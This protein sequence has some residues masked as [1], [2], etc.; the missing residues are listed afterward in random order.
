MKLSS[1]Y[2]MPKSVALN[3]AW[4]KKILE[5]GYSDK[6]FAE[7]FKEECAKDP[8]LFMNSM[9]WILESRDE[10]DWQDNRKFGAARELP[11]IT[12][13][14]QDEIVM[15]SLPCLGKRDIPMVK[16]REMGVSYIY[17]G[18]AVWDAVFHGH[19]HIGLV[20]KDL[21]SADSPKDPDALFSKVVFILERLPVWLL[22]KQGKGWERSLSEHTIEF[23]E[24][25]SSLTA[26][27]AVANLGRGG[28]KRWFLF[29]EF[30]FFPEGDDQ[31]ALDSTAQATNCRALIS[32]VNR[33]RGQT[34]AFYEMINNQEHNGEIIDIS[35]MD[36][37]EKT[38]GRYHS[39]RIAGT[40]AYRLVIDD[41]AFWNTQLNEDGTYRD[42][43][44]EGKNYAFISDGRVRSLYYDWC[45]R[46]PG[47]TP[48][49]IAAELD[50]NFAGAT[51]SVMDIRLLDD[52]IKVARKP[53]ELGEIYRDPQ[54]HTKWIFD[55]GI[56]GGTTKL[57]LD[58]SNKKPPA[59][60]DYSFGADISMGTGG[61][62]SSYSCLVGFDKRT[63]EQVFE[64][65]SNTMNPE[66]FASLA[67][68][69]CK[70]FNNAYLVPESNGPGNMFLKGLIAEKYVTNV[71]RSR[72]NDKRRAKKTETLGYH[73]PD[74]GRT[75]L[76]S[77]ELAMQRG[78]PKINS[79]VALR[80][81]K[82]YFF[83]SDGKPVHAGA[84][85]EE[86]Q[87]AVG[88]SHGDAAIAVCCAWMGV[89]DEPVKPIV[90]EKKGI[91]DNCFLARRQRYLEQQ[92][93]KTRV[94][95]WNPR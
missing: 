82:R 46:R 44:H 72:P 78:G 85:N 23:I 31:A 4:R 49:S 52:A 57:W 65:R 16:S 35:W 93:A 51:T 75:L 2:P 5:L 47:A 54:D 1:A 19:T 25:K 36:D 33:S 50:R 15:R 81:M 32:T 18:L 8:L 88:E 3:V 37:E 26:Y 94:P 69:V 55:T 39:E 62:T 56:E 70:L 66:E 6:S 11:F 58:W 30:H 24:T 89:K 29:D 13:P 22:D 12:R 59:I 71:W 21:L 43:L 10:A 79:V 86:D 95:Y 77:L 61:A 7:D 28:R 76:K 63:N 64:W 68:F 42:P 73:N 14:Y 9:M 60:G 80:E 90:A 91:P 45:C 34:G 17:V 87:S 48:Q 27:A 83:G 40:D 20:S 41:V 53:A 67:I 74:R 84:I 38:R 92:A